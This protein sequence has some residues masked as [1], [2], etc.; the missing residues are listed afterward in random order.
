MMVRPPAGIYRHVWDGVRIQAPRVVLAE[1]AMDAL[2]LG[3]AD[4]GLA[5]E[6]LLGTLLDAA[7]PNVPCSREDGS[8]NM[9]G[10]D[11][12]VCGTAP[13][14]GYPVWV[15][16]QLD[17][18]APDADWLRRL[19]R[20]LSAFLE[21]WMEQ[22]RDAEGFLGYACSWESGQDL[23]PRFG[24]Q[25]LGGGHP[26]RHIRPVDLHA[27]MAQACGIMHGVRRPAG[28]GEEADMWRR[29][30]G[31]MADR[32]AALWN[33]ERW[34]DVDGPTGRPTLVDDVMLAAPLALGVAKADQAQL[35]ASGGWLGD[36]AGTGLAGVADV[37]LD[38]RRVVARRGP[39]RS[40][41]Q[42]WSRASWTGSIGAGTP[43]SPTRQGTPGISA[44]YWP[45]E[46]SGGGEGYGWGAF[47]VHLL[48][49]SCSRHPSGARPGLE[50]RP[51]LPLAWRSPGRVFG[52]E[53]TVRGTS[54]LGRHPPTR[55]R[56][57][58]T[59]YRRGPAPAAVGRRGRT[60]HRTEPVVTTLKGDDRLGVG[61][62][63]LHE[64]RTMLVA[65]GRTTGCRAVAGCDVQPDKLEGCV[66]RCRTYS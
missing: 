44:E 5:Q 49:S 2:V 4:P 21:W 7:E 14:W 58:G 45:V 22:R 34:A 25:P 61:V 38:R 29:W 12:T 15:A 47:G 63:G 48:L 64:G 11:G 23:S 41:R 53:L 30:E 43:G 39:P 35:V 8:Y 57:A 18:M 20:P 37:R 33:G 56:R 62:V 55:V 1:T 31:D 16:A 3:W 26:V 60:R 17:A 27:A 40:A 13:E 50:L 42:R 6:L 52:L 10:A 51:C 46:G 54:R 24:D 32:T 59:G 65:C 66:P 36:H 28:L 9:V 19:Y